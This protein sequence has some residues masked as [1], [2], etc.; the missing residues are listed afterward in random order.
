[1]FELIPSLCMRDYLETIDFKFTDFQK[2][3]LIW[4]APGKSWKEKLDA[5]TKLADITEEETVRKQICE[6]LEFE[7]KKFNVFSDN[8]SGHFVYL[9]EDN[10]DRN[11]C[12]FFAGY[13]RA[14]RYSLKYTKEYEAECSIKKLLIVKMAED[15]NVRAHGRENQYMEIETDGYSEYGGEVISGV[16]LN[17]DGEIVRIWSYELP[18][19]DL[20]SNFRE[21]RFE[22]SFIK[23]PF[24]M[25][26]GTPVIDV[27]TGNYGILAQG[28]EE[29][30]NYLKRI[31]EENLYVD[32]S[33]VQVSVYELTEHGYW[34]HQHINPLY[35]DIEFPP[36]IPNN[37]ER[38][39][40]RRAME[41]LGDY[42]H[43]NSIGRKMENNLVI[44]YE[45]EYAEYCRRK[46]QC[47]QNQKRE[48]KPL[49]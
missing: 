48:R 38:N 14:L 31:E 11:S 15:E 25:R 40:L 34:S 24:D 35:L 16:H 45:K 36:Y 20:V 33:D 10:E 41:A 21:D 46:K 18:E 39:S 17:K 23:I 29:W 43:F 2:A 42:L 6:R 5:L 8:V 22:Y 44:K 12:A 1:M 7:K 37:E 49:L 19:E 13:A 27:V 30:D 9:V 3:T 28:K 32:Y 26:I 4:N 47:H